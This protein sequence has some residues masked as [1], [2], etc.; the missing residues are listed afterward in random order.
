MMGRIHQRTMLLFTSF[1]LLGILLL[2]FSP[3]QTLGQQQRPWVV[4]KNASQYTPWGVGPSSR[5][6]WITVA[7]TTSG[8]FGAMVSSGWF[9][10]P[11]SHSWPTK[12]LAQKEADDIILK[13][14]P[15][16]NPDDSTD[17][18]N[19]ECNHDFTVWRD[20][21][22]NEMKVVEGPIAPSDRGYTLVRSGLCCAQ[23]L[24]FARIPALPGG[25]CRSYTLMSD[26]DLGRIVM[27]LD[28]GRWVANFT[29]LF[30]T[31]P[32]DA[33]DVDILVT[34]NPPAGT[35][36]PSDSPPPFVVNTG[37]AGQT[38]AQPGRFT[39]TL[40]ATVQPA[41][42]PQRPAGQIPVSPPNP[43][44]TAPSGG[45]WALEST[46]V[47]VNHESSSHQILCD[48]TPCGTMRWTVGQNR[49]EYSL[50]KTNKEQTDVESDI[51][52]SFTFEPPPQLIKGGAEITLKV[53]GD[54]N[55]Q[56]G[57]RNGSW[58]FYS[59]SGGHIVAAGATPGPSQPGGPAPGLDQVPHIERV[60][61]ITAPQGGTTFEIRE[62]AGGSG[63]GIVNFIYR[64]HP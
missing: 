1:L 32:R 59:V 54:E 20:N 16:N 52:Y 62:G 7:D 37:R 6:D 21:A 13:P 38:P 8:G 11:G 26:P 27:D 53:T 51:Q 2:S 28:I 23:A 64:W 24:N 5:R 46:I 60:F 9:I 25:D 4:M 47:D 56:K 33:N 44:Q 45:V 30:H 36:P 48:Q 10:F 34:M 12:D 39:P 41:T 3:S 19:T 18:F 31:P 58:P 35:E 57:S 55:V 22:T 29:F 50:H 15:G 40:P 63:G 43:T 49:F 61:K 42:P 14:N 17:L